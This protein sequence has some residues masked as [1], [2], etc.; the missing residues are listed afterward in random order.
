[1]AHLRHAIADTATM[2]LVPYRT[3]V[4]EKIAALQSCARYIY[5]LYKWWFLPTELFA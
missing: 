3:S 2:N 1:M 5:I 4:A